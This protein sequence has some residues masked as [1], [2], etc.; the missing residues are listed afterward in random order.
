VH[1]KGSG[2]L[3]ETNSE[4]VDEKGNVYYKFQSAGFVI[5]AYG[6][7]DAGITNAE[8]IKAPKGKAPDAE[9]ELETSPEQA[10]LYRLSA[11]YNPLH[12][13]PDAPDVKGGGFPAPILMG[14]CT[15]GHSA[16]A[17]L[18]AFGGND[19]KR[20]HAIKVRFTAPVIPG[21]T[22]VTKMWKMTR[23]QTKGMKQ[24]LPE[25]ATRV[26]F[27]TEVKSSKKIVIGNAYMD[28]LGAPQ[29]RL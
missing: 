11:D 12:I 7:T 13:D 24:P 21:D 3:M 26:V 19:D 15:L 6:F 17:V 29:A 28:V 14:L 23:E 9:I 16:R 2:A 20:F 4:L 5:G 1:K 10:H 8:S 22:L 27:T 25:G 18:L